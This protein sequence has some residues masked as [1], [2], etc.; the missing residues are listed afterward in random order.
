MKIFWKIVRRV[1]LTLGL[2]VYILVALVNYSVVQS[3]LGALAGS[4]FSKEWGGKVYIGSLHAM[5]FDHLIADNLLWISPTG[6]TLLVADQLKATFKSFPYGNQTL[7]FDRVYLKNAYYHFATENHKTNLQFLIDYFKSDKKEKKKHAPFTVKVRTLV[8]DNVHYR[9]D[10]PDHRKTVYAH[11]VQIPHMEFY[12]IKARFKDVLVVNDDVTCRI[13]HLS[14]REKSGFQ[15][16]EL[17]GQIHVNRYNVVAKDLKVE[18]PESQIYL[19][20]TL[21]YNGWKGIKGYVNTVRHEVEIKPGTRVAMNDVAYWAPTLWG[22]DATVEAEGTAAGTIDSLS[23]DMT[24]RWGKGSSAQISGTV[25][26]LPKI[27]NT[28]FDLDIEHLKTD[29]DDLQFLLERIK[30]GEKAGKILDKVDHIDMIAS[31]QGGI[32]EHLAAN[33]LADCGLG[34]F[35]ADAMLHHTPTGYNLSMDAQSDRMDLSLLKNK[36]ITHTG[37]D[38]SIDGTWDG[39]LKDRENWT[40]R[41]SLVMNGHFTNSVVKGHKLST[42]YL[43]GEFK[44]GQLT[45]KVESNDTMADL[46]ASVKADLTGEENL[47]TAD[48]DIDNLDLGLLP[49]PVAAHLKAS[50]SGEKLD[51]MDGQLTATDI[52]YGDLEFGKVEVSVEADPSG[53]ELLFQSD[54]ANAAVKGRFNYKDLPLIAYYFKQRYLPNIIN[55]S[56]EPDSTLLM[57]LRED[58]FSYR[59]TWKDDGRLLH[60]LINNVSI[61]K[62]TVI[63]GSYNFGEQ[64]KLVMVSD[65]LRFGSV[66]LENVGISGRPWSNRYE[67]QLDAQSITLGKMTLL[68]Q[69]TAKVNSSREAS[70]V[71]LKWGS[72]EMATHGNVQLELEGDSISVSKPYFYI[73]KALWKLSSEDISLKKSEDGRLQLS[74]EK[75]RLESSGQRIDARMQLGG[76]A[77]DCIE[78]DFDRFNLN[79]LCEMLLQNSPISID[80]DINGHFSLFGLGATPY[81]VS[82]L[83]IDSC[84]VN[85]QNLGE[86]KLNSHWN[87][88][89][90]NLSLNLRS[91]QLLAYGWIGLGGKQSNLNFKAEFSGLELALAQPL[92][93]AFTSHIG[94]HLHGN[95]DISGSLSHPKIV[96]TAVV[97]NG[98]VKVDLTDVTYYFADSIQFKNNT[99]TLKDFTIRDPLNNKATAN[100]EIHI[101]NDRK[102][103]MNVALA[104]DNF[105]VL[106]KKSGDRF[107]GR[108]LA[109]VEG[110]ASGSLDSL[111]VKVR[112][113]TNPGCDITVPVST[114]QSVK[115]QNYI[116]FV[117]DKPV[118]EEETVSKKKKT[119]YTLELDLSLTPDVKIN[120]PMNFNEVAVNVAASGAGDLHM[121]LNNTSGAKMMGN[122]EISSG[123]M[124][125]GILSVY[126]KRFTIEKGSSLNFQGSVPDARFDLRAVYSQRVNLSTLTG[127]LSSVDNT[128]KY[129]QVENIIAISGSLKDPHI[130]F[131]LRLP[132]AD[133]SVEE[134][135]FA[136]IDRKSERDMMNQTVSLLISGSFYNVSSDAPSSGGNP[137]NLVT[138]IVGNSLTDM[139]QFVDVNIDYKSATDQTNQ[140][141]DVNISK[142][143]GRWYLESTL[144]YGGESRE[145]NASSVNGAI[146]DALIGYRLSSVLHLYAYNRTNTN[147][148]TRIDLPYK[149]GI[150]LKITKDFDNWGD[151]FKRKKKKK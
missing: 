62:G 36:W 137:L 74:G 109:S 103:D 68:E 23:T 53:K 86:V 17:S 45:A 128:Q 46:V 146:I 114:Q 84:R 145:I 94:G 15:V 24:V 30:L 57:R 106:N 8:L 95:V 136:Y 6:D 10:L 50:V 99:I 25:A 41:L 134:E 56:D 58:A 126:E 138:S 112:A 116:T 13:S 105:L 108:V 54:F 121:N 63:D 87:S 125:V 150:G 9:M 122:Y 22:T 96:G 81:F 72:A 123:T 77:T 48:I 27:K 124:K 4:Y 39:D 51:D 151:L 42:T 16:D 11:G 85:N 93:S 64:L 143:W 89:L 139:V 142:D 49:R 90:D 149:Q 5:P 70:S 78:L 132:N 67:L 147:D 83:V 91:E 20:A 73:G 32:K 19:N 18:T 130:G 118:A 102:L 107:Y 129:I 33:I 127:S 35:R 104:T 92:L 52:R 38:V 80:G 133:P 3:Y 65:S 7:D 31:L 69:L 148:Y 110:R 101:T 2:T 61:A 55:T 79:L 34:R 115:S 47:Y 71:G 131:D 21:S 141:L 29:R 37:F 120:L 14:T 113:R 100:G 82:D 59:M 40:R 144:G 76:G 43:S 28:V 111:D 117:S 98:E 1:L 75:L 26:G 66:A 119:G 97:G 140:Q 60:K 88:E 44:K 135:V 12:G